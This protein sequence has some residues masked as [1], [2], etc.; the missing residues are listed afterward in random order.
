M[1]ILD[2][3]IAEGKEHSFELEGT[4]YTVRQTSYAEMIGYVNDMVDPELKG[5]AMRKER[6]RLMGAFLAERGLLAIKD[7]Q[8]DDTEEARLMVM[9]DPAFEREFD[10]VYEASQT[11]S[12][13]AMGRE[14]ARKKYSAITSAPKLA[15]R[16]TTA[17]TG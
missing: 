7:D 11:T 3:A 6:R 5:D 13:F 2:R 17:E 15:G 16:E 8:V 14:A 12:N 9:T 10:A 1:G 4:T